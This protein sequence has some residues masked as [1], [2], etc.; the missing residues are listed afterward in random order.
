MKRVMLSQIKCFESQALEC[1]YVRQAATAML[2]LFFS[3]YFSH[4]CNFEVCFTHIRRIT[5]RCLIPSE[6]IK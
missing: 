4:T 1:F 3:L 5:K 6:F 2:S